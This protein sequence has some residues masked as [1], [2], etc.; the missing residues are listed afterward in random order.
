MLE[1]VQVIPANTAY[2]VLN[3]VQLN[4]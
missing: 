1:V 4:I 2:I 3:G